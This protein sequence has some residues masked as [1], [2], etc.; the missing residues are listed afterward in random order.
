MNPV[1][2]ENAGALKDITKGPNPNCGT[3]GFPAV[4]GWVSRSL[5]VDRWAVGLQKLT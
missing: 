1:L 2:Y 5:F 4:N 3:D